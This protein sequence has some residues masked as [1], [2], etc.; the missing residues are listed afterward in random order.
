MQIIVL[1][2]H[3]L[4]PGDNPWDPVAALGD[5]TVYDR[6]PIDRVVERAGR[7]EIVL[8]NKTPLDAPVLA[9]LPALR[10][11]SVLAT[12][13][14]V[15]DVAAARRQGIAVSNVPEY[16]TNSVAQHVMA[17]LLALVQRPERHDRLVRQGQWQRSADFC[18]WDA[19]LV[20]LAGKRMGI[21]GFGRIGGRRRRVGPRPGDGGAGLRRPPPA[22][23]P[24]IA[25][26][27]GGRSMRSLPKRT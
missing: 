21:V 1:D 8:T 19:P 7:A 15:V 12:G 25:P 3:T 6:T 5:L 2:G 24:T 18:F 26:L 4:N 22:T 10:F 23:R 9:A 11:I 16:G 14:N 20:E 13:F 17:L 27:P